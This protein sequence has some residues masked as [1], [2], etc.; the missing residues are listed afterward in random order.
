MFIVTVIIVIIIIVT[1]V[2]VIII[3]LLL[4][5]LLQL[6]YYYCCYSY[7]YYL[8][9]NYV[10]PIHELDPVY[11]PYRSTVNTFSTEQGVPAYWFVLCQYTS[12]FYNIL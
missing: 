11:L 9:F 6:Y 5:L 8:T 2:I 7:A 1:V 10:T 3:M 12:T 4:P